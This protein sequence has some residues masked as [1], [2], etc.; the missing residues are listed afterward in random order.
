[1]K[2]KSNKNLR[3]LVITLIILMVTGVFS[4]AENSLVSSGINSVFKGLFQ[5]TAGAAAGIGEPDR[6]ELAAEVESLRREN[7]ELREKLADYLDVKAENEKLWKYY[8]LKKTN[9]S[10]TIVPANVIRRDVNDDFYSFTLDAGTSV[11]VAVNAPVITDI[12]LVGWVCQADAAACKVK[13]I[14]SPDTKAG[15]VGKQSGDSGILS[16]SVTLSDQ[17]LTGMNQLA[18]DNKLKKGDMIVT[19][20][21]GGVYPSG[22]PVGEVQSIEFNKYDASRC[23]VIK[24][25]EDVRRITS[26][27]VITGF[28]DK[29]RVVK[30]DER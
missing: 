14:L 13:T 23:A 28:G 5:L 1:M 15:V 10:Y 20:G 17:N 30:T 2:K 6:E 29:G 12:G 22:L 18:E 21:T 19:S 16:G 25:Y 24:P 11:G 9:P 8:E 27:A 7:A 26:A 4:R 3:V